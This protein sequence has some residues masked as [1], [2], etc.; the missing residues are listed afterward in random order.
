[1]KLLLFS[2]VQKIT[3]A[4]ALRLA[5]SGHYEWCGSKH[6]VRKMRP[7]NSPP[8]WVN[9]YRTTGAAALP[10]SIEWCRSRRTAT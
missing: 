2:K 6:R 4:V 1:V 10:P 8:A 5:L 9:C 3:A 7:L